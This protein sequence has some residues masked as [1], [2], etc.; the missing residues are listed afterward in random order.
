MGPGFVAGEK[1]RAHLHAL[2]A[3][4]ERRRDA[5]TIHDPARRDDR[6]VDRID[7]PRHQRHRA[8]RPF[9]EAPEEGAAVTARL[10]ALRDDRIRAG[11][12][13]GPRLGDVGGPAQDPAAGP[14]QR[15]QPVCRRNP[16]MEARDGR[17]RIEQRVELRGERFAHARRRLLRSQTIARPPRCQPGD[18]LGLALAAERGRFVEHEQ[19]DA[20][21]P[22]RQRTDRR[23]IGLDAL[24]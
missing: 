19:I 21:R 8:D 3:E 6:H 15:G 4:R 11:L 23:N 9:V 13:P 17:R 20:E 16:E 5:T 12:C 22:R 10:A 2:R 18:R 24:G 7:Q 14:R 1:R